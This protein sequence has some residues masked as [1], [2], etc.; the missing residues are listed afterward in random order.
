M[1]L[2]ENYLAAMKE[3]LKADY[4]E[5]LSV[6]EQDSFTC[7]RI[8]TDKITPEEFGK[9]SPFELK[10]VPWCEEGFY[11]PKD[12]RPGI[13][14]YYYAGLYYIQ[15]PSAMSPAAVLPVEEGDVV[16]D[17]CAAPGG[18]ST[19]LACKLKHTGLLVSN[20]ISASRQ[21]ATLKN[22]ERFGIDNSY[23]IA[24]DLNKLSLRFP[25]Y[26][27][28][29]LLDAPCSGEGMFRKDPSL[30]ASWQEKDFRYFAPLQKELIQNAW[31]MLKPGGKM[32]YSTCTFSPQEDEEVIA[33]LMHAYDD[34]IIEHSPSADHFEPGVIQGYENC[35]RL[36]PHKLN[37]EGHFVTLLSKKG[38]SQKTNE[39]VKYP[40]LKHEGFEQFMKLIKDE[41]KHAYRM[42]RDRIY[43]IPDTAFDNT[44]LRTV[45]SG[46]YM[47]T[48]KKERFEPSQHLAFSLK[49]EQFANVL[50]LSADDVRCEKYLRSETISDDTCKD[51]WVLVCVS[52]YPLGF[53][54][55]SS[56]TIKN[57]LEKGYRKI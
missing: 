24:E 40:G 55:C 51:G 52:G 31:K 10:P 4:S 12:C 1:N 43:R 5:Y 49:K 50:D 25:L 26:F 48:V 35:M 47:G 15:E 14:P 17:A 8:N 56:H 41:K 29:I 30:I 20:D 36:Y 39:P 2:P 11:V 3:L 54:K 19:A 57:K 28:K 9:I 16:L 18:K 33:S 37:G 22:M 23:I 7:I 44:S 38:I 45:L 34:V 21:N 6:M 42:I 13:H 53:G 46:L 32:V 27:D